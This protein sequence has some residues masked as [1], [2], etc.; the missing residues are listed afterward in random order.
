[1]AKFISSKR[2]NPCP[3]CDDIKGKCRI[4]PDSD[5]VLCMN[6]TVDLDGWRFLGLSQGGLW[7]KYVPLRPG[8]L[9]PEEKILRRQ[10]AEERSLERLAI[11]QGI[12][13]SLS[14]EQRDRNFR[15]LLNQLNLHPDDQ[16]DLE[17]RGLSP[18]QI[19]RGMFRSV[20]PTLKLDEPVSPQLPGMAVDGRHLTVKHQGYFCPIFNPE[21]LIIGGQI[22]LRDT[23]NSK[24]RWLLSPQNRNRSHAVTS[25]LQ[26]TG[27]LPLQCVWVNP[28][29][30]DI[31]LA[32][33]I[34]K[35]WIA[36]HQRDQNYL[37]AAGGQFTSSPQLLKRNLEIFQPQRIILTPDGGAKN[38]PHVIRQYQ[39]LY[40][41]LQ[42]WGYFLWV[43]WW[44]QETKQHPDVD[45]IT[46]DTATEI[47][48]YSEWDVTVGEERIAFGENTFIS[49][50]E[51]ENRFKLP[52][53]K[54]ELTQ[55]LKTFFTKV[56]KKPSVTPGFAP[57]L[58]KNPSQNPE[59]KLPVSTS[60]IVKWQ[61][62]KFSQINYKP[63]ELPEFED[64]LQIGS[65]SIRFEAGQRLTI[66]KEAYNKG[67]QTI[68]DS[69][70]PGYGK[71]Y[72][73]G[74]INL[75]TFDIDPNNKDNKTRI[76][77]LSPDHRNPTNITL[78]QNYVDLEARHEGLIQDTTRT[79]AMGNP[80]LERWKFSKQYQA[81]TIPTNCPETRTF[82]LT[83]QRNL[84]VFGGQDS[85]ICQSCPHLHGCSFLNQRRETLSHERLIRADIHS[86]SKPAE[87]DIGIME[88]SGVNLHPTQTVSVTLADIERT[89][90]KLQFAKDLRIFK[91]LRPILNSVYHAIKDLSPQNKRYGMSHFELIKV[92]PTP[93][94]LNDKI[95]ELYADDWLKINDVW[96]QPRYHYK[97]I[98][99]EPVA[100]HIIGE[101][102]EIPSL[103]DLK[104]ECYRL[105]GH[106]LDKL[107]NGTMSPQ[108]KQQVIEENLILNWIAPLVNA[109]CGN[110]RINLQ[111]V[112]NTLTITQPWKRHL[113]IV[114]SFGFRIFLDATQTKEDLARNLKIG[115]TQILEIRQRQQPIPNLQ[116]HIIRGLGHCGKQRRQTQQDRIRIAVEAIAHR[117]QGQ[118]IA[119]NDH[120]AV[121]ED[122]QLLLHTILEKLGYWHRDTRG[123]NQFLNT[124]IL[125]NVGLPIPN[126]GQLAAQW[127]ALTGLSR[128]P[129][130]LTGEYGAWVYRKIW[131]EL[132]Q[133][134]ARLRAHLRQNE[135]L[136]V[137]HL[138]DLDDAAVLQLRLAFPGATVTVEDV[139]DYAPEAA[140][141]GIQIER[142]IIA[143]MCDLIEGGKKTT[144]DQVAELVGVT[145]GRISQL[146]S[147]L[148]GFK[149]VKKTLIL[150][151]EALNSKTKLLD[152][153]EELKWMAQVY[154]PAVAQTLES[155]TITA[156]E[157]TIEVVRDL[158][159]VTKVYSIKPLRLILAN[160]PLPTLCQL[161]RVLVRVLPIEIQD[162][163]K[164]FFLWKMAVTA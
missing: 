141:K 15:Q 104:Q 162:A 57:Q 67:Y 142:G 16:K 53:L 154:L 61:P 155:E 106:N 1:M 159:T 21:G 83:A 8:E 150:L 93:E 24:Y 130:Q 65:P 121:T 81:P 66:L 56:L 5:L 48:P 10:Q 77:Y 109:L 14:M 118:R 45:E 80:F 111:V 19:R 74:Q 128:K 28:Q 17:R 30:R 125:L 153:P 64:W 134:D 102:W 70:P 151:L 37:G 35:P 91:A 114:K 43:E 90:G 157:S 39:H 92:L 101:D 26:E 32:E 158:M 122:Y 72:D 116:I 143:T 119:V 20:S 147:S 60:A 9:T 163:L 85:P 139:Y 96:G 7:G 148:G 50:T 49:A 51:W 41:L 127:Q 31:R 129:T 42:S 29:Q 59:A 94:E 44:G 82:E 75:S 137:Y 68:K 73:A 36:A 135:Q 63:G 34:L 88:E 58:P 54:A 164:S 76:F 124:Q 97:M 78:E 144:I 145:Q 40:Q 108:E 86:M 55:T 3:I 98:N 123:S 18:E 23:V 4:L 107:L 95:W 89:A 136:H 140:S 38:N 69:T 131:A 149:Q 117:H 99:G 27:E 110:R 33:G 52:Q 132:I 13:E 133:A 161:F 152:L 112:G 62:P 160:T 146:C 120:K 11:K 103:H 100:T 87:T 115:S 126:L 79:T 22:R 138:A 12:A 25:H 84:T 156:E 105:L 47:I 71:S 46:P 2:S 6:N 113:E